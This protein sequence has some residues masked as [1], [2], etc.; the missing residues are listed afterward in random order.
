[1]DTSLAKNQYM[2]LKKLLL[3]L[4]SLMSVWVDLNASSFQVQ[5]DATVSCLP[6][7]ASYKVTGF[8]VN[9]TNSEEY[10][11]LWEV[12]GGSFYNHKTSLVRSNSDDSPVK[13]NWR[14]S[15]LQQGLVS[16]KLLKNGE[17]VLSSSMPVSFKLP[18]PNLKKEIYTTNQIWTVVNY[19][20]TEEFETKSY[21]SNIS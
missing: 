18:E 3:P 21:L 6:S 10:S 11:W 14:K 9:E 20:H 12:K 8:N 15:N 7:E 1:M 4:L 17:T 2:Y 19:N 16:V 5:G 13:I